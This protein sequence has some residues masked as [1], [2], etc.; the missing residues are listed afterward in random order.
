[1]YIH[2]T[3]TYKHKHTT[4]NAKTHQNTYT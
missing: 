1:M 4:Y 2:K 3:E